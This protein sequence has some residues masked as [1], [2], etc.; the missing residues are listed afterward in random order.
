MPIIRKTR[1]GATEDKLTPGQR[2]ELVGLV[3]ANA[4][5]AQIA[6]WFTTN[7][8]PLSDVGGNRVFHRLQLAQERVAQA[9][10]VIKFLSAQGN[11]QQSL[12][13]ARSIADII[14]AST[15]LDDD[16]S[17]K[18][19][20]DAYARITGHASATVQSR[21]LALLEAREASAKAVIQNTKLTPVE[22][23]AR[24]REI[25]AK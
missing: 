8:H 25:F 5:G 13:A 7:G 19:A 24:L 21:R 4:T 9:A 12:D 14:I 1:G 3:Q 10:Q 18:L 6:A 16:D 22:Q 2:A 15:N 17:K 20:L 23:A 11:T